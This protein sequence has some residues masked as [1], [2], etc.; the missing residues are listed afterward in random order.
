[1]RLG[2]SSFLNIIYK[3]ASQGLFHSLSFTT[4]LIAGTLRTSTGYSILIFFCG[5]RTNDILDGLYCAPMAVLK[6]LHSQLMKFCPQ[7]QTGVDISLLELQKKRLIKRSTEKYKHVLRLLHGLLYLLDEMDVVFVILDHW[8]QLLRDRT[9][10]DKI[11]DKLPQT[12]KDLTD[13][14]LKVLVVDALPSD[15]VN[16]LPHS[17]LYVPEEIDVW[18]NDVHLSRL[19]ISDVRVRGIEELRET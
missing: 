7:K 15:A 11:I 5:L 8:S 18:R 14:V 9:Q 6:G 3:N 2:K 10:A 16:E 19:E 13:M 17:S 12:T 4:A 1:M